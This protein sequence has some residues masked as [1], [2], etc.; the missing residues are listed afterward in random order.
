MIETLKKIARKDYLG[1][2]GDCIDMIHANHHDPRPYHALGLIAFDHKNI[3]KAAELFARAAGL[4]EKNAVYWAASAQALSVLSRQDE[5]RI[6]AD[7]AAELPINDPQTADTVA[8]VF[9]RA[10]FHERAIPF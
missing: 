1:A 8:V 2:H 5:A 10:G 7:R 6:S 9:S 4:D 3:V